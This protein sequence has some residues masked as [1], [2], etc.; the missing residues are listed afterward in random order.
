M[1]KIIRPAP[2]LPATPQMP[3]AA[4]GPVEVE[5]LELEQVSSTAWRVCDPRFPR[6]HP[7]RLLGCIDKRADA[8]ELMQFIDGFRW[9]TL[10]SLRQVLEHV[11]LT[12]ANTAAHPA[13]GEPAWLH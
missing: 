2:Q 9:H 12:A 6:G 4:V 10:A 13:D 7:Q 3:P 1:V 11:A 8:F 5:Q